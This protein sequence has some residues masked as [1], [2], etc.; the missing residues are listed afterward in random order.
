MRATRW[1][2]PALVGAFVIA[3]VAVAARRL[4]LGAL[5][6]TD[7]LPT[8]PILDA[9]AAAAW[10]LV[11]AAIV[12][13]HRDAWRTRRWLVLGAAILA[14]AEV[15]SAGVTSRILDLATNPFTFGTAAGRAQLL[16]VE[17]VGSVVRVGTA[18]GAVILAVGLLAAS[19][20]VRP[21]R[22]A[23]IGVAI[24]ATLALVQVATSLVHVLTTVARA[25]TLQTSVLSAGVVVIQVLAFS[26]LALVAIG[27]AQAGRRPV[28]G[29][30]LVA[31]GAAV[32]FTAIWLN[33][34]IAM[35]SPISAIN[36]VTLGS[37]T[38]LLTA[39]LL[40]AGFS[41]GVPIDESPT[42]PPARLRK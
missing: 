29:W 24:L 33:S 27:G 34:G 26:F 35:V 5:F 9:A 19:G 13:R 16:L 30:W 14:I 18:T 4:A 11:G 7:V 25:A 36:L 6:P 2:T 3:A 37:A 28:R 10:C 41:M 1:V 12:L 32:P 40:I 8:F 31:A 42:A 17:S 21:R 20:G 23:T 39:V 38:Q 15:A 22:L